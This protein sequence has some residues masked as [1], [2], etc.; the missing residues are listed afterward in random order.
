[1]QSLKEGGLPDDAAHIRE[2]GIRNLQ[3]L[4]TIGKGSYFQARDTESLL[5]VYQQ[6]D[7]LERSRIETY[8]YRRYREFF[9]WFGLA[10]FV[11]LTLVSWLELTWWRRVP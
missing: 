2:E 9:P 10:C 4:A 5:Q 6:I 11:C 1:M 7:T 3:E 8:Q